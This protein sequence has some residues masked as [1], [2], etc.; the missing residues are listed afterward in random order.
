MEE[1]VIG[2]GSPVELE[3]RNRIRLSVAAYAYEYLNTSIMSDGEFD[4]LCDKINVQVSTGNDKLD[5][6]FREHFE[7]HTGMWICKH[8]EKHK[9][10]WLVARYDK[11]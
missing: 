11:R 4:A 10:A 8:P 7:P 6:F 9:L 2:W 5:M 1:E 3:R